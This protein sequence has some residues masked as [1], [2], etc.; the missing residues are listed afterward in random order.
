LKPNLTLYVSLGGVL[1]QEPSFDI[2]LFSEVFF[3]FSKSL[4]IFIL[5]QPELILNSFRIQFNSRSNQRTFSPALS[6]NSGALVISSI[7]VS[8]FFRDRKA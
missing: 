6:L 4:S 7:G 5:N 2:F 1:N 3:Y 8:D